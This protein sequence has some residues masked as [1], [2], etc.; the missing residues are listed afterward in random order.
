M[1]TMSGFLSPLYSMEE[2]VVDKA[3]SGLSTQL[4][5]FCPHIQYRNLLNSQG[6]DGWY[7]LKLEKP[8][9][10]KSGIPIGDDIEFWQ[11]Q[12]SSVTPDYFWI[13]RDDYGRPI[14]SD[15]ITNPQDAG[16]WPEHWVP[17]QEVPS[18]GHGTNNALSFEPFMKL[19]QLFPPSSKRDAP[20]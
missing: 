13:R 3:S 17:M 2:S 9:F 8:P 1:I 7:F 5:D 16:K 18:N 10:G 15:W 19:F 4:F 14:M 12:Y 20:R 6:K 11:V